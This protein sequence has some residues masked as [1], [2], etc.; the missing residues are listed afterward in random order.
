MKTAYTFILAIFIFRCSAQ[1]ES[2]TYLNTHCYSFSVKDDFEGALDDKLRQ[3][4]NTYKVILLAQGGS[5]FLQ[6]HKTLDVTWMKYL[7]EILE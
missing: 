4:L 2:I 7:H 1:N 5:H 3:K 6:L